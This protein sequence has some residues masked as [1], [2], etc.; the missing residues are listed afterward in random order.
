MRT[1]SRT[2]LAINFLSTDIT[3]GN[4]PNVD[5]ESHLTRTWVISVMVLQILLWSPAALYSLPFK[6]RARVG[7]GKWDI[8]RPPSPSDLPLEGEETRSGAHSS[9]NH[10][11]HT[12]HG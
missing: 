2:R 9:T 10:S 5:N 4:L 8:L 11:T 12:K 7:V 1:V 3:L 6:G